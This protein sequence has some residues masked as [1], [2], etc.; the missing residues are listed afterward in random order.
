[1]MMMMM[2]MNRLHSPGQH[3]TSMVPMEYHH[4]QS[5]IA[6][7]TTN[8]RTFSWEWTLV[9]GSSLFPSQ[10][11]T[12]SSQRQKPSNRVRMV[13]KISPLL[14]HITLAEFYCQCYHLLVTELLATASPACGMG[15]WP[16]S[17]SWRT[18]L[19]GSTWTNINF[20]GHCS[21]SGWWFMS[22]WDVPWSFQCSEDTEMIPLRG[23]H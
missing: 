8:S 20:Q 10:H 16:Q 5:S 17:R 18:T 7:S 21:P 22:T 11:S 1:M 3:C 4:F 15:T 12:D 19:K 9:P 14:E 6:P 2:M 23:S 13:I